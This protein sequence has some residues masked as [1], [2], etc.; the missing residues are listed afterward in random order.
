[1]VVE[2]TGGDH[3]GAQPFDTVGQALVLRIPGRH[4]C[5]VQARAP[6]TSI[7]AEVGKMTTFDL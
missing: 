5:V 1:M 4:D 6:A 3:T 2:G 7:L